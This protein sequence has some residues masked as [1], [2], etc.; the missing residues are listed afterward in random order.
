MEGEE[1]RE[2]ADLLMLPLTFKATARQ[3][4]KSGGGRLVVAFR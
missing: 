4:M 3:M 2:K 1:L